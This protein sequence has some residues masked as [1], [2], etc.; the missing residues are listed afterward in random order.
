MIQCHNI[1]FAN[2]TEQFSKTQTTVI[3]WSQ[4]S[5]AYH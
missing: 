4:E 3:N 1:I 5:R 2:L